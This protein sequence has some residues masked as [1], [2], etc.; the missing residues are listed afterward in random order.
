MSLKNRFYYGWVLVISFAF[1]GT[2]IW[3]ARFSFGVFFK[4]LEAEF[5][6][7]R[8]AT[9]LIY[10]LYMVF[11]GMV[12]I[13]AGWA[14]DKYG[15]KIVIILMGVFA[16]LCMVLTSLTNA[17]WQL[18]ITY[19]LFLALGTAPM[20]IVLM[21]TIS[22]WF[23]KKRGT[24]LGF[25][26]I[27]AGAGTMVMAPLAT[28]LITHFDWRWGFLI[29]GLIIWVIVFPAAPWLKREPKDIGL[30]PDGAGV[31]VAERAFQPQAKVS[32]PADL[33]I[34]YALATRSFWLFLF[35]YF[36]HAFFQFMAVTH[37]VPHA[38]DMG[39]S[40]EQGATVLSLFGFTTLAGRMLLGSVS[41]R[42]GKKFMTIISMLLQTTGAL[43]LVWSKDLWT[44][45]VSAGF[46]GLGYGGMAP[47]TAALIGDYF[48]VRNMGAIL[49]VL[50]VGFAAGA[51]L[52]PFIGG[53]VFDTNGSYFWA[54][55]SGAA[56]M[57]TATLLASLTRQERLIHNANRTMTGI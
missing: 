43:W 46:Y 51:A 33:S 57:A 36:F 15:P 17:T 18:F 9:S 8:A 21:S 6:L 19:S 29:T 56:A 16:G 26:S 32:L 13:P 48:G 24:A 12:S 45:Y 28:F 40:P 27:G 10:S 52:G 22:R 23:D 3:G 42:A 1:I 54:F 20:Y 2:L 49:G 47:T 50:N 14:L 31:Y 34:K 7:N 35:A 5:D 37:V 25:A 30:L 41:D 55:V 53:Y 11:C 39:F 38:L 44:F 4:S